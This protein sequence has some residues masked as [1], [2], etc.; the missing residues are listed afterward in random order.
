VRRGSAQVKDIREQFAIYF[1]TYLSWANIKRK[2]K[3]VRYNKKKKRTI[4]TGENMYQIV[5]QRHVVDLLDSSLG[6]QSL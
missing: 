4:I 5:F 6:S 1:T 3:K 2:I